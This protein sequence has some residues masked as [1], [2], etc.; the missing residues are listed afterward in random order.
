PMTMLFYMCVIQLP[1]ALLFGFS[2]FL[3][4]TIIQWV[5][6]ALI[7]IAALTAHFCIAKAMEKT[8]ASVVVTL[9]FLRLPLIA[10]IG[11][12]MYRENIEPMLL[13]GAGL[14]LIGNLINTCQPKLKN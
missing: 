5:W 11:V 9:D 10:A 12:L 3:F 14:M 2:S 4:P 6:L 7:G 13:V 1:I 8:D